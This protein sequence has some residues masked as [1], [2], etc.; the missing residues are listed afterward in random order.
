MVSD[1]PVHVIRNFG[2]E[3]LHIPYPNYNECMRMALV[4]GRAA[5]L[6]TTVS[7]PCVIVM[8]KL[9][10]YLVILYR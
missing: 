3:I 1:Q 8:S 4:P 2:E 6:R 10:I 5:G 9:H 7:Q